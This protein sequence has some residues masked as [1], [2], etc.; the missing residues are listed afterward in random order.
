MHKGFIIINNFKRGLKVATRNSKYRIQKS[1]KFAVFVHIF[2]HLLFV[3]FARICMHIT[4]QKT[5][6][7][8]C[9]KMCIFLSQTKCSFFFLNS[10]VAKKQNTIDGKDALIVKFKKMRQKFKTSNIVI[11]KQ[12][13]RLFSFIVSLCCQAF[14]S[15]PLNCIMSVRY[16]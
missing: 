5:A 4:Q 3:L 15:L 13:V 1:R 12:H 8:T 6:I 10:L 9:R 7:S 16:L 11:N 14:F 2:K